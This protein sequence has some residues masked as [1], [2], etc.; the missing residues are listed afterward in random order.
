MVDVTNGLTPAEQ[1]AK[2]TDD[3][4][5]Y[6]DMVDDFMDTIAEKDAK[7]LALSNQVAALEVNVRTLRGAIVGHRGQR[8]FTGG[9]ESFD[10]RLWEHVGDIPW[11]KPLGSRFD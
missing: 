7:I 2:L 8:D 9:K 3:L 6:I 11:G 4:N 5:T 10:Y 1:I